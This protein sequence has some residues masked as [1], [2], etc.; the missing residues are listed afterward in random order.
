LY[1]TGTDTRQTNGNAT[2]ERNINGILNASSIFFTNGIMEEQACEN[3][4]TCDTDQL[5]FKAY[6]SSWLAATSTIAPFT[7]NQI[8]PLLAS[9]A[10]AAATVC[11]GGKSGTQCGFKWTTGVNDGS[12]GVGQQMSA[13]GA[14]QSAMVQ[15]PGEKVVAPVT[16]STGGTSIGDPS[17]GINSANQTQAL[18]L[19]TAPT[20]TGDKVG[21]GILT[22]AVVSSIIGGS[23]FMI[24][25]G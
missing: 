11:N 24:M 2:W 5:S 6:F 19:D 20:T 14:I 15:I 3:A 21:A 12:F 13:L 4:N 23:A 18:L 1:R 16:N 10:K 17:A 25:D 7:Y 9:T 22:F 8:A